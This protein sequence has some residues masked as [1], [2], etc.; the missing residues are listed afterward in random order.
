[1]KNEVPVACC[2]SVFTKVERMNYKDA[3]GELEKRRTAVMEIEAGFQY[4]FPGDSETLRILYDWI[5]LERKC[6]PFLTFTVTASSED[7]PVFLQLTGTE[8]AKSFLRSEINDMITLITTTND[9]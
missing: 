8:D 2:H 6:C 4:Q 7:E 9:R 3:W 5:S 1:M